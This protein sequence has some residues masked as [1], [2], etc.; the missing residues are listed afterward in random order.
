M[1]RRP[2]GAARFES[3]TGRFQ[4][5]TV[6]DGFPGVVLTFLPDTDTAGFWAG[7]ARGL[8]RVEGGVT[9]L[10]GAAEGLTHPFVQTL[11][12]DRHGNLWARHRRRPL[13]ISRRTV[14]RHGEAEGLSSATASSRSSRIAKAASG[15]GR[16]TAA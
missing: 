1:G 4:L 5:W 11:A 7:T 14:L 15:S 8:V 13:P 6:R 12:R 3:A 2:W 9:R 16:P 10:Y